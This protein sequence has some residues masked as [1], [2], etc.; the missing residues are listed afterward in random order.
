M[1]L[2]HAKAIGAQVAE[3]VPDVKFLSGLSGKSHSFSVD[4]Q[5]R[6]TVSRWTFRQGAQGLSGLSGKGHSV[7]MDF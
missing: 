3:Q 6:R 2:R 5:A 1:E 4:F 7:L